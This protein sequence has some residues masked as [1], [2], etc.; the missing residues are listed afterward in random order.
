MTQEEFCRVV[1]Q[2]TSTI[3]S[4]LGT[5]LPG[6][7]SLEKQDEQLSSPSAS[8]Q[9]LGVMLSDNTLLSKLEQ[10]A[11]FMNLAIPGIIL[12]PKGL[13]PNVNPRQ[14]PPEYFIVRRF[15]PIAYSTTGNF[16]LN[17]TSKL[18]TVYS[19]FQVLNSDIFIIGACIPIRL[20]AA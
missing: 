8:G 5:G 16:V 12:V 4:T 7:L 1:A 3:S 6:Q 19:K 18:R 20:D 2:T 9:M 14:V 13:S 17:S 11:T 10:V 15:K